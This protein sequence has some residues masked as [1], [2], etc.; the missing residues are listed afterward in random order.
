MK[1]CG[2]YSLLIEDYL[3]HAGTNVKP[4]ARCEAVKNTTRMWANAQRDANDWP[5][6][7]ALP[8][9][10]GAL[11]TTPQSLADAHYTDAV[12]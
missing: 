11:C 6:P 5:M 10:G 1:A 3:H 2:V 12:Q 4:N 7:N 9:I 8:N